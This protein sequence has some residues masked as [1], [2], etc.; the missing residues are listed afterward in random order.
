MAPALSPERL[1]EV[2]GLLPGSDSV[3]LK[4]TVPAAGRRHVVEALGM[5]PLQAELRHQLAQ[6]LTGNMHIMPLHQI[7][8]SQRRSK[9]MIMLPDQ[10]NRVVAKAIAKPTVAT[11]PATTRNQA[12]RTVGSHAYQQS[13]NLP[14]GQSEQRCRILGSQLPAFNT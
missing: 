8:G 1:R 6:R 7:L 4:V 3:E 14:P 5:D 11:A 13:I 9:I 10:G 12:W 2:L